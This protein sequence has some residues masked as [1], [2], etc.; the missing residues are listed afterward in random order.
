MHTHMATR[1][2]TTSSKADGAT[3]YGGSFVG[4]LFKHPGP[5]GWHFVPVPERMAPQVTHWWGRT[6]VTATVDGRT[7]K[8]SVWREKVGRTLLAVPKAVRC[9]KGDGDRVKVTLRFSVL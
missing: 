6:P 8:T 5:G 2:R 7:W 9:G 3:R 1:R 4:V